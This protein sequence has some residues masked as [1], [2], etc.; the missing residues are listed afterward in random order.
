MKRSITFVLSWVAVLLS[1]VMIFG[2]SSTLAGDDQSDAVRK[3]AKAELRTWLKDLPGEELNLYGFRSQSE[4]LRADVGTPMEIVTLPPE[5]LRAA[6]ATPDAVFPTPYPAGEW[7]VPIV[8]DGHYRALLSVG[9]IDGAWKVFGLSAAPLAKEL[10]GMR[11]QM[12]N[13]S[14][15]QGNPK[16]LRLFVAQADFLYTS[17]EQGGYL[18]PLKSAR[19]ALGITGDEWLGTAGAAQRLLDVVDAAL[20]HETRP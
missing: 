20:A 11:G 6:A 16:L 18:V 1:A 2:M 3:A 19:N 5:V 10:D 15:G 9:R 13:M 8:V 4:F 17:P 7:Y 14:G 12:Q